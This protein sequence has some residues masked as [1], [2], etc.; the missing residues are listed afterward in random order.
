MMS[1]ASRND[2]PA[3][4]PDTVDD[5]D[6]SGFMPVA[7]VLAAALFNA[8]LAFINARIKPLTG[9][10]V[11]LC[12][13]LIV[14]SA[15]IYVLRHFQSRMVNWYFLALAVAVFAIL[16]ISVTDNLDAKYFRDVFLIIT[17]V[18]LGMTSNEQ[19]VIQMMMTLM[20][21]VVLGIV[22]E[23][24]CVE[25]YADV[26]AVKDFYVSTRG[27]SESE[28][29]NLSSDLY[30]SATRPEARFLPFFDL[31]RLSSIFLE[32]VSLGNF[33]IMAMSFTAA[34]WRRLTPLL[35][36]FS[37]FALTLML[38]ACD[39]R[40]ATLATVI[41]LV[42]SIGHRFVPRHSG[43]AFLPLIAALAIVATSI[44]GL[45]SGAD[46]LPGRIAY[47]AELLSDMTPM[48]FAGLSDRLLEKSVDAG[49]V[50]LII[51]QSLLGVAL[52]WTFI[53]FSADEAT[54]EQKI[55]KNGLLLYL[56]LTM[57]VSYSYLSIKTAAPIWFIFGA[58]LSPA[59]L[60]DAA[61]DMPEDADAP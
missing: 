29:T 50:Y 45:H 20:V 54:N 57:M 24:A 42:I 6:R 31:H 16:R 12:E 27:V 47:T 1:S 3:A 9:S 61:A 23:A 8:G 30:V 18:L 10:T 22:L 37:V 49:A 5:T 36:V 19:R 4:Y 38:F 55:Y 51:T 44:A 41:I 28:F 2:A 7:I 11:I 59:A 17:F 21:A 53:T 14:A 34:F 33:M 56:A 46:D 15:H 13:V 39:G 25:C 26:F 48:D 32:P 40:L 52:L 60:R 35:R 43:L 58:L